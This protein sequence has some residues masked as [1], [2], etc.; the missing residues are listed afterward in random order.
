MVCRNAHSR[1]L[2]P[3]DKID[4]Q[5][6]Q[7]WKRRENRELWMIVLGLVQPFGFNTSE[8]G[9]SLHSL[10]RNKIGCFW[11]TADV[12]GWAADARPLGDEL[13]GGEP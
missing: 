10:R 6:R 4:A 11:G 2:L 8:N 5:F 12:P 1:M 13:G 7:D 9:P 3:L